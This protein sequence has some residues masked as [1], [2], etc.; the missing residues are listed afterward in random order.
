LAKKR[1]RKKRRGL[2]GGGTAQIH[3]GESKGQ[4][5]DKGT[6]KRHKAAE[7]DLK[8]GPKTQPPTFLGKEERQPKGRTK[9]I[10]IRV[11]RATFT[12]GERTY[13]LRKLKVTQR[14]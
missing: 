6:Q 2:L 9:S 5:R 11:L 13:T 3:Y 8:E 12:P 4:K 14:E 7:N 10:E 1:R